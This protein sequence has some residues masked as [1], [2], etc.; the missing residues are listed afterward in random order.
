M[1]KAIRTGILLAILA[2]ALYSVNVPLSKLLLDYM[3]STLMAGF[4]YLGAG[5]GMGA[6]ALVRRAAKRERTESG[7]TKRELPY[8]IAMILLD[9]AAPVCLLFGLASTT[10]ANASLLNNFEIV[11][12]ALIALVVFR[13][14]ISARLWLGIVFVTLSCALLSFEDIA[15]LQFSYGSLFIL[16][17]CV[18]WG[19]E[20]NCTRKISFKDPQQIVLL[21][22]IFSGLGSLVIGLI[23]EERVTVLWSV[24]A[25]LGVGF[26]AYGLSIF[27]Y[28][29]AQRYLGAARTSAYYAVAPF[30]GTALSLIIFRD[31]P[32]YTYF[33]ALGLMAIGAWLSS[34]DKPL[35]KR[36]GKENVEEK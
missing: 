22:G 4:L 15:S 14:K 21:K 28:V 24:F 3:P 20:N 32:H 9:I 11:A 5:V 33:I 34:Q 29:Y 12:T 19:F 26:V 13:E 10:A 17:A 8:V 16:L 35:F 23:I 30:L 6:I 36:R 2:A 25:V 27:F 31:M 18:C 1:T 7:L